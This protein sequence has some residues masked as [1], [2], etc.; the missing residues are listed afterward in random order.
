[1]N[2]TSALTV[3]GVEGEII[4][5]EGPCINHLRL[6]KTKKTRH[7]A[8]K[9]SNIES[10]MP[11]NHV[12][13]QRTKLQGK[14]KSVIQGKKAL[15]RKKQPSA[16]QDAFHS[17]KKSKPCRRQENGFRFSNTKTFSLLPRN[18]KNETAP[19]KTLASLRQSHRLPNPKVPAPQQCPK[20]QITSTGSEVI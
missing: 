3:G 19:F 2:W 12:A 8:R 4:G 13:S 1:M 16:A 7:P 17:N 10:S 11:I 5:L 9:S 20:T 6:P 15:C 14:S 18:S